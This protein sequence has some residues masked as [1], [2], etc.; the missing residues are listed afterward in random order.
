[1]FTVFLLGY[2]NAERD[3]LFDLNTSEVVLRDLAKFHGVS[4]ALKIK[5]PE[6]FEKNLKVFFH[7]YK[8]YAPLVEELHPV[9]EKVLMEDPECEK[10]VPKITPWGKK[11][12]VHRQPFAGICHDDMWLSNTMQLCKD[13]KVVKNKLIDFQFF[14]YR[15]VVADLLFLLLTSV[16]ETVLAENLERLLKYYHF[17]LLNTLKECNCST[18][19]FQ[20]RKF[21]EELK[22]EAEIEIGHSLQFILFVVNVKKFA[23][24]EEN[25]LDTEIASK[26][27]KTKERAQFIVK[28][29]HKQGW[30]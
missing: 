14:T 2:L 30:L 19:G 7:D 23:Y 5:N 20:Y 25:S 11:H 15:S 8:P 12:F 18:D 1:M 3:V 13:G 28:E 21:M 26:L 10:L 9:I 16:Q 27:I 6:V 22:I 24:E 29:C 17:H 4:L